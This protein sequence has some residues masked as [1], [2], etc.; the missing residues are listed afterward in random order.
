MYS[1]KKVKIVNIVL[2]VSFI[3]S[4]S[5][6]CSSDNNFIKGFNDSNTKKEN[7]Q[8]M[9]QKGGMNGENTNEMNKQHPQNVMD[10]KNNSI[11]ID[12]ANKI[13]NDI[14]KKVDYK[15]EE[16][17]YNIVDTGVV[18]YYSDKKE[19]SEPIKNSEFY[20][21]DANYINNSPSYTDNKD[22]TITDNNT[23][24]I[25]QKETE[26][27]ITWEEAVEGA[28][29]CNIG[30]YNDWR[31]PTVKELYSLI[32]FT[33]YSNVEGYKPYIDTDYFDF[34]YGDESV[35]RKIDSQY[36]TS[37]IYE[38]DTMNGNATMFG[39]NFA[40]GRI[41]GYPISNK[42]FYVMYVRGN[43]SYGMNKFV[44]NKDGT[45]TDLSTGTMWLTYDSG[46]LTDEKAMD[47]KSALAWCENLDYAGYDDWKL[48]NA[49]ELQSIVDY[50]RS[51]DT[52]DSAAINEMFY[53]SEITDVSGEKNYPSYWTSTTHLDGRIPE[54]SAVYIS[55]GEALGYMNNKF[56]DV[57]G[58][59][60]QRSDPKTGSK[61]E[62]PNYGDAPQGDV[63]T[64]FN[65]VRAVRVID[66][67][68][69]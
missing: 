40:D 22:G 19:I 65:Y 11:S 60:A 26:D 24:L 52:T 17:K 34:S 61:D 8:N 36:A 66:D 29:K 30:G 2:V 21:Q 28:S 42:K 33:G 13:E 12:E 10:Q 59:G 3:F 27:K 64:V 38:S 23:N 20:G 63:R 31:L 56:L 53:S 32:Q 67:N 54:D 43:T 5:T 47:W 49:K 69:N 55:F 37:T 46:Y 15:A 1:L 48:P 7:M 16:G 4:V 62:Y 25:W 35:E 9:T 51:P 39:V 45:I 14:L 68:S 57:H 6:G 41:K 18:K 44:D 58:A 50:S